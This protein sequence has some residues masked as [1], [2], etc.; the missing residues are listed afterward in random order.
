MGILFVLVFWAVVGSIA[1]VV[2][3]LVLRFLTSTLT[4][5][6]QSDSNKLTQKL[7][8]RFATWLP[9][10][11][12]VWA[13]ILFIFQGFVNTTYL[14]RDLGLGDSS[15]CPLPNGYSLLMIDVSD[16][17]TV[18]NPK[19]QLSDDTVSN[20]LGTIFGVRELQVAGINLLGGADS[21]YSEHFGQNIL[22]PPLDRY[23]ILN[24]ETGQHVD[25]KSKE[26]L[27][28]AASKLGVPL[29]LEPI[30]DV[31]RR[32]RFIWFDIAV[33]FLLILPLFIAVGLL[34]RSILR[35]RSSRVAVPPIGNLGSVS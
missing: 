13:G 17:G 5:N 21:K 10:A 12:L 19:S 29:K 30:F 27:K 23:F 9:L 3:A 8:M 22:P 33:V 7:L 31:Y 32:Y 34:L 28:I 25:F 14:H 6:V 15:Y 2:G 20:Q 1:A 35:L 24:T 26:E 18:Y 16:E 11:C 4:R